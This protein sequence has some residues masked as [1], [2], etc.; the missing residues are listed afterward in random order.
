LSVLL[1]QHHEGF[2]VTVWEFERDEDLR[3]V[4]RRAMD[5][6]M[7]ADFTADLVA[8]TGDTITI[9]VVSGTPSRDPHL[10]V[11]VER[12]GA[13]ELVRRE[14]WPPTRSEGERG[15]VHLTLRA[16]PNRQ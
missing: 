8:S 1:T 15:R 10:M 4:T 13:Y 6:A 9:R 12:R 16:W 5:G 14:E 11:Y 7:P 3:E 2:G